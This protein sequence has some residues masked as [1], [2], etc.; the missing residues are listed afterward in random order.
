MIMNIFLTMLCGYVFA[1]YDKEKKETENAL[2]KYLYYIALPSIIIYKLQSIDI[3][4][5][6]LS[7]FLINSI[8]LILIMLIVYFLWIFKVLK[9]NFARTLIISATMGNTIYLGFPVV[10]SLFGE[11]FIAYAAMSAAIQNIVIFSLGFIFVNLISEDE[12]NLKIFS[13][14]IFKNIVFLSSLFSILISV[15]GL[16]LPNI[17]ISLMELLSKTTIPLSLF[18]LG[19][20]LYGSKIDMLK[21][22]NIFVISFFKILLLPFLTGFIIY[23]ANLKADTIKVSFIEYTMPVAVLAFVVSKEL[24]MESETVAQSIFFTTLLYFP[25]VLIIDKILEII[26]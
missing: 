22:K 10:S 3:A 6:N 16:K 9:M 25:I 26:I 8:P 20:A 7:F 24:E 12:L 14:H 5:L 2:N 1:F 4:K 17:F 15:F 23:F 21:I 19:V 11:D 18:L 13:K